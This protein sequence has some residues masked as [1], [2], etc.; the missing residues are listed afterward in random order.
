MLPTLEPGPL[1]LVLVDGSHSFPQVFVDWF[2]VATALRVGG[3]LLVDD[4]HVWTGRVLRDFLQAEPE[5]SLVREIHGR[6]AILRKVAE[7]DPDKLWTQQPYGRRRSA[8][9]IRTPVR[10]AVSMLRHGQRQELV[11][12]VRQRLGR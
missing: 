8:T 11:G 10:M 2:Y 3:H 6:T 4:V 7:V 12:L 1:D 5:W 9:G